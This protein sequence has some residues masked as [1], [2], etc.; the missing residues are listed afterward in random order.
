MVNSERFTK[1]AVRVIEGGIKIASELGHTYVG[2][3]HILF[4]IAD[5]N[6]SKAGT[7][8]KKSGADRDV[9]CDEIIRMVGQGM[10]SR[11]SDRYFTTALKNILEDS[12]ETAMLDRKKQASPEH[13]LISLLK[14][15][16][17]SAFAILKKIGVNIN[18][19]TGELDCSEISG[20]REEIAV[21][22]QPKPSQYPNL[23]KYGKNITDISL[24]RKSEK[25]I[26]RDAETERVLQILAR[27]TKNNPCLIGQPGVG[28]TAI[29]N[30][31]AIAIAKGEV[32]G[33]LINKEV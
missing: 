15:S 1:R 30:A 3:E 19:L 14:D 13:I 26:G 20:I 9:I 11:L 23:F 32:P 6:G 17:C 33:K 8:L 22:L 16:S 24:L 25:L 12:V 5:K 29:V 18:G 2:S 28:K 27:K 4:A 7:A 31:L 10:Q 21:S